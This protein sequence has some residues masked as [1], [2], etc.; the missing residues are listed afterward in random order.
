MG[1]ENPITGPGPQPT[2][3]ESAD[4]HPMLNVLGVLRTGKM[5]GL[6][7]SFVHLERSFPFNEFPDSLEVTD[8]RVMLYRYGGHVI[9]DSVEFMFTHFDST[10][11]KSEYRH[12]EFTPEEKQ[13]YGISC[14]KEGFPTLA[15]QTTVP[16]MPA[17][18]EDSVQSNGNQYSFSILRD[19]LVSLYDIYF[20]DGVSTHYQRHR[21]PEFGN[22]HVVFETGDYP[23]STGNLLIYAYDLN[24]SEYLAYNVNIK[25]NTFRTDY[26]TVE[27]G[28][29]CFG[30]L[31]L[32]DLMVTF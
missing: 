8:A 22:M 5:N 13:T 24:L 30:S 9:V 19:T 14:R 28:F 12:P 29:G 7:L 16:A 18:I 23:V 32:L 11:Q 4:F 31:N 3:L 21:I 25:P 15:S 2:Y 17:I 10:F 1:C 20:S 27:D 6:G 26:S